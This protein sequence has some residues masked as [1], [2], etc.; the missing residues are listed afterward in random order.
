MTDNNKDAFLIVRV[1]SAL[2]EKLQKKA[3][4]KKQKLS[5]LIR[6][7]LDGTW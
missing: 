6:E 3:D 1:P 4:K 7:R 5:R 2:K